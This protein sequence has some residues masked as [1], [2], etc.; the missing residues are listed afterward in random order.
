VFVQCNEVDEHANRWQHGNHPAGAVKRR[1]QAVDGACDS[2]GRIGATARG[3]HARRD[4]LDDD[5]DATPGSSKDTRDRV[6]AQA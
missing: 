2:F 4:V 1:Q 5:L 6:R 3:A